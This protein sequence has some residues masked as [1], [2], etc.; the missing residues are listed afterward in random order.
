LSGLSWV[1]FLLL[2]LSNG[3]N[4]KGQQLLINKGVVNP[5]AW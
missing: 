4:V 3:V 5:E 2:D 1:F